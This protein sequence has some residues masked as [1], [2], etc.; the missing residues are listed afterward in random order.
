MSKGS[1]TG[2]FSQVPSPPT[3]PFDAKNVNWELIYAA[4]GQVG[5]MTMGGGAFNGNQEKR[6]FLGPT[7]Q[8]VSVSSLSSPHTGYYPDKFLS[9]TLSQVRDNRILREIYTQITRKSG[10]FLGNKNN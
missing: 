2:P 5:R 4:A 3:S 9:P 10:I 8:N 1:P 6:D 7:S